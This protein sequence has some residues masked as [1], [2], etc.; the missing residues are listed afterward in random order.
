MTKKEGIAVVVGGAGLIAILLLAMGAPRKK[1]EERQATIIAP[2]FPEAEEEPSDTPRVIPPVPPSQPLPPPPQPPPTPRD[3]DSE[4][5]EEDIPEG[6]KV[7]E[8]ARKKARL[9]LA[10]GLSPSGTSPDK[11]PTPFERAMIFADAL[12]EYLLSG[13]GTKYER[14]GD[15]I[16][17]LQVGMGV[18]K[19]AQDGAVDAENS[20]TRKRA[21]ELGTE[22]AE[23]LFPPDAPPFARRKKN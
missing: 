16:R 21:I 20:P 17:S 10:S 7:E 15:F 11:V 9:L 2:P 1:E 23:G 14:D 3:P 12:R 18:P 22:L 8:A 4:P 13:G 5:S 19:F 6:D